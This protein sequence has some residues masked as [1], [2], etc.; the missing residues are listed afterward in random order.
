MGKLNV[1]VLNWKNYLGQGGRYVDRMY[2]MVERHLNQPYE[3]VEITERDLSSSHTGWFCKLD[4]FEMFDGEVLYLDLDLVIS[5]DI[6]CLVDYPRQIGRDCIYARDDWSYPVM[7]PTVGR[8]ATINS[9][10]M[11]WRG[12]RDMRNAD[13]LIPD[14][15]GDQGVLT[16][17]FWASGGIYLYPPEWIKS[18][19]Y[20]YL[21]G[22]GYSPICVMHGEP[23]PHELLDH[24]WVRDNWR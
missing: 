18:Y 2:N 22:R 16:Q 3:F 8:E 10:V 23:K 17:L 13:A 4:L 6:D 7:H 24:E 21:Q 12:S 11:Y 5:G 14:M 9:S 15:H 19:K 20:D 1:V